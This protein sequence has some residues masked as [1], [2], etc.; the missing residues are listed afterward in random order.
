MTRKISVVLTHMCMVSRSSLR[1]CRDSSAVL[2]ALE[3][4]RGMNPC[5]QSRWFNASYNS[6]CGGS[7]F[8]LVASVSIPMQ[9]LVHGHTHIHIHFKN[10]FNEKDI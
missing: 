6:S 3:G 8:P 2:A 1:V 5:I 10:I 7:D 9:I 4:D